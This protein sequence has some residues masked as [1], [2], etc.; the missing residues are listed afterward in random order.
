MTYIIGFSIDDVNSILSDTR[1]TFTVTQQG[2]NTALKTG[3]LY[4]G[5]IYGIAGNV[6]N[7]S[8][9][10]KWARMYVEDTSDTL[11]AWEKF[12]EFTT[13][14]YDFPQGGNDLFQI[15]V[16][17][18]HSGQPVFY[19]LNSSTRELIRCNE[20]WISLGSGKRL[21]DPLVQEK[22]RGNVEEARQ[23]LE[24]VKAP[25]VI[26][27]PYLLCLMLSELTLTFQR[28]ELEDAKV[29]GVFNFV[30]Q[31]NTDDSFQKP[32]LY[33]FSDIDEDATKISY[34]GYRV[35][36]IPEGLHILSNDPSLLPRIPDQFYQALFH[37]P[38]AI[39]LNDILADPALQQ[40]IIDTAN[41]LPFYYFCGVGYVQP[42]FQFGHECHIALDDNPETLII[43]QF[44]GE[45]S[46]TFE[47]LIKK[48]FADRMGLP[49]GGEG[50]SVE[51]LRRVG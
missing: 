31:T 41:A 13:S 48:H 26:I 37:D 45:I 3:V 1:V 4:P 23:A 47:N 24:N 49:R 51:L 12:K 16:S 20:D 8:D 29:G 35:C 10:I 15:L 42:R 11:K 22:Y 38:T 9:F 27:H 7:A 5:C 14:V 44:G 18:R 46:E 40:R 21:L 30:Y 25:L 6:G 43:N 17:S 32:A 28:P 33:I 34:L 50:V 19:L 2:Q 36:H 39:E